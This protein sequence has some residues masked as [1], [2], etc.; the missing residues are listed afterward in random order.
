[1][2]LTHAI[3]SA[4]HRAPRG[5]LVGRSSQ[6]TMLCIGERSDTRNQVLAPHRT[7]FGRYKLKYLFLVQ[8]TT[9]RFGC[10]LCALCRQRSLPCLQAP[11]L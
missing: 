3:A 11:F 8:G 7:S 6:P 5:A 2:Y 10:L 9:D 4:V 1:M